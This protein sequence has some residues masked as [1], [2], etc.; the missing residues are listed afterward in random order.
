MSE[1]I[2]E[3]EEKKESI[4]NDWRELNK[5]DIEQGLDVDDP[6]EQ[7]A[8]KELIDAIGFDPDELDEEDEKEVV[9]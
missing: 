4:D 9:E 8:T 7:P 3:I 6:D 1:E 5:S 2:E